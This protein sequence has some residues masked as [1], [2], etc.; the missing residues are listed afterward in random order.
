LL[1]GKEETVKKTKKRKTTLFALS[2]ILQA[3]VYEKLF[4]SLF[5]L[6]VLMSSLFIKGYLT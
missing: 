4:S 5:V 6:K 2:L 1:Q 3:Y